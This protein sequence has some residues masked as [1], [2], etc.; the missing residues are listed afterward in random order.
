MARPTNPTTMSA[1]VAVIM[2]LA[3]LQPWQTAL[4]ETSDD[5]EIPTSE[6]IAMSAGTAAGLVE[7]CSVDVTPIES[8]FR[9]FLAQSNL[10][11][12]SQQSLV[13][14]FKAAE[15]MALSVSAE[16]A[17]SSCASATVLMRDTVHS[18]TRPE[19]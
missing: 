10:P 16:A 12:S 11:S 15:T 19:L 18:L 9:G 17:P 5:D 8:A 1:V 7:A 4:A 3:F 6:E 13:E 14:K 2:Q